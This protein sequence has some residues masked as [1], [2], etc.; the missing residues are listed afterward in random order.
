MSG[1]GK[2]SIMTGVGNKTNLKITT[3]LVM[4]INTDLQLMLFFFFNQNYTNK[5]V[6]NRYMANERNYL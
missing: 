6:L 3:Y 2:C 5:H 1:L 4:L